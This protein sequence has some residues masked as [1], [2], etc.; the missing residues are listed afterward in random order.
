MPII[1]KNWPRYGYY[2]FLMLNFKDWPRYGYYLFFEEI[3]AVI[4]LDK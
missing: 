2:L 4:I 3:I 1:S